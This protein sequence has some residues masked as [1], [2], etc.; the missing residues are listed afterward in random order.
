[1][2]H[3]FSWSAF[4]SP[5]HPV[6]PGQEFL[7]FES[8]RSTQ[9]LVENRAQAVNIAGGRRLAR[10]LRCDFWRNIVRRAE[11]IDGPRQIRIGTDYFCQ[12]EVADIRLLAFIEKNIPRL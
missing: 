8:R 3:S 6:H 7:D 4:Y 9:Q 12:A 10:T 2:L 5:L 11:K 1:S